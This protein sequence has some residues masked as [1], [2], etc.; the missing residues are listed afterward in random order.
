MNLLWV[1]LAGAPSLLYAIGNHI[2]KHL[3]ENHF[4]MKDG[5]A[6]LVII[7][8]LVSVVAL[9]LTYYMTPGSVLPSQLSHVPILIIMGMLYAAL[10]WFYFMALNEEDTT[11]II[12][13]YSFLPLVGLIAS[14]LFLGEVLLP[15]QLVAMAVLLAGIITVSFDRNEQG[16]FRVKYRAAFFM[17]M[18]SLCW[19]LGDVLFKSIALDADVWFT[20]FWEHLVLFI[21]GLVL[22]FF[23]SGLRG[24]L[25]YIL[26]ENSTKIISINLVNEFLYITANVI[27]AFPLLMVQVAAVHLVQAFQPVWVFVIAL[28]LMA[29]GVERAKMSRGQILQKTTATAIAVYGMYLLAIFT[30]VV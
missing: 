6:A 12:I 17:F 25:A 18:A 30:P 21:L 7:S 23:S 11:T 3:L 19:A 22:L 13:F 8:A 20:L 2:D 24:Q 15:M 16:Q 1:F 10:L 4:K 14:R 5:V 28:F 27:S 9:P 29:L 26:R